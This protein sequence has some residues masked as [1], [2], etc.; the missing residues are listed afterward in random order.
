MVMTQFTSKR[1]VEFSDTD[2]AGILHFANYYR[3]IEEAEHEFF[4]SLGL[5]IMQ[6]LPDGAVIGWPRVSASCT[7]EAPAYFEDEL[8][9]HLQID[10][11]G[12]KSLTFT[13]EIWRDDKRLAYGKMKTACCRCVHGEPLT[14]I[15]IP[16]EYDDK[17]IEWQQ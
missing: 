4:R 16:A 6:S 12:V 1:R 10:R 14:S 3:Y 2:M 15:E 8:D 11:K 7:Y 5:S 13:F 9:I 17:L